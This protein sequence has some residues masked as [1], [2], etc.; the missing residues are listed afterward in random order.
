M[1]GEYALSKGRST[2]L[3]PTGGNDGKWGAGGSSNIPGQGDAGGV[4][5]FA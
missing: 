1:I 2:F 5:R 4:E 3:A